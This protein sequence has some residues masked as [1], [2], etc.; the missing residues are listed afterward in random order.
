MCEVKPGLL[1]FGVFD[2]HGGSEAAQYAQDHLIDHV[3]FWIERG[4]RNLEKVLRNAFIDLNNLFTRSLY[5]KQIGMLNCV[6]L[7][8]NC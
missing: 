2:G 5:Q 8:S 4:E 6:I 3:T 7:S 1:M